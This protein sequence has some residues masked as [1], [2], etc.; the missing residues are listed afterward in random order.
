[1]R[2]ADR[3][4]DEQNERVVAEVGAKLLGRQFT[5]FHR[6]MPAHGRNVELNMRPDPGTPD[7]VIEVLLMLSDPPILPPIFP[8]YRTWRSCTI[9]VSHVTVITGANELAFLCGRVVDALRVMVQGTDTTFSIPQVRDLVEQMQRM[10]RSMTLR[11][12]TRP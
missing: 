2:T 11:T 12:R 7:Y 8:I 6:S 4:M 1:M 3:Q 5:E 10:Q 9:R